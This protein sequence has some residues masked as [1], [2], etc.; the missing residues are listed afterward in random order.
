MY[1]LHVFWFSA[2]SCTILLMLNE[3]HC[4]LNSS[5][6]FFIFDW[7]LIISVIYFCTEFTFSDE[8]AYFDCVIVLLTL[9]A[10]NNQTVS[11]KYFY[12]I[13]YFLQ[14]EFFLNESVHLS[15]NHHI[16]NQNVYFDIISCAF[17]A[18]FTCNIF[19]ILWILK[20]CV[21]ISVAIIFW[22]DWLITFL[23]TCLIIIVKQILITQVFDFRA[24]T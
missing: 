1:E 22:F 8:S 24:D 13:K 23:I 14:N 4:S 15:E 5:W 9:I 16:Y 3:L 11:V 2:D 10:A 18:V 20:F 12:I 21:L 7:I 6:V 19:I 17:L